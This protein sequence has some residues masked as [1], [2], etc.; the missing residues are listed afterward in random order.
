MKYLYLL[1]LFAV[2]LF[3]VTPTFAA[4]NSSRSMY[5]DLSKLPHKVIVIEPD[6]EV[7]EVSAGGVPEKIDAWSVQAKQNISAA[8]EKQLANKHY[9]EQMSL[10][11]LPAEAMSNLNEHVALYDV[12]GANAY[13]F[14]RAQFPAWE[15]KKTA[16]D[17]TLG[18]GLKDLG[19]KTGAD[20]AL[21]IIGQDYVSSG[22]RKA[23]RLLAAMLGVI[24]PPSPTFVSVGLVDLKT[25]NVLWMN[26]LMAADSKDLRK[27]EDVDGILSEIF[28]KY[29][30]SAG[31]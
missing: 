10:A 2:F 13:F 25:G 22:G 7:K 8:L 27:S 15:H 21:F 16:F 1:G 3:Q 20:A 29:P 11:G 12:V 28:S 30:Q 18:D 26:Y 19:E 6:V 24:L 5:L 23:T 9:F 17:Y 14:G 31:I 4:D